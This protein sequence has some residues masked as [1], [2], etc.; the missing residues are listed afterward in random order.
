MPGPRAFADAVAAIQALDCT[1]TT[2]RAQ[3]VTHVRCGY[4]CPD[5]RA[6]SAELDRLLDRR[7]GLMDARDAEIMWLESG[8]V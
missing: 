1:I 4:L 6:H 5:Y 2:V 7:L 3:W 8:G